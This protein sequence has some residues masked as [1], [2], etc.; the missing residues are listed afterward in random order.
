VPFEPNSMAASSGDGRNSRSSKRLSMNLSSPRRSSVAYDQYGYQ[1]QAEALE[2]FHIHCQNEAENDMHRM[3]RY[4]ACLFDTKG[5]FKDRDYCN[6]V[7]TGIPRTRRRC[8][9]LDC[10]NVIFRIEQNPGH[11]DRLSRAARNDAER[12][13][14]INAKT[15]DDIEKDLY[16]I[17]ENCMRDRDDLAVMSRSVLLAYCIDCKDD[18]YQQGMNFIVYGMLLLR[19]SEEETFWM[20]KFVCQDLFP[21]SFTPAIIGVHADCELLKYYMRYKCKDF[22]R[23]LNHYQI[24]AEIYLHKLVASLGFAV[25]PQESVYKI[26]DRMI[27]GGAVEFFKCLIKLFNAIATKLINRYRDSLWTQ[28]PDSLLQIIDAEL[29][30]MVDITQALIIRIPGAQIEPSA[31]NKRRSK[32]RRLHSARSKKLAYSGRR[33]STNCIKE[34]RDKAMAK[35]KQTGGTVRRMQDMVLD[36]SSSYDSS[37]LI[38]ARVSAEPQ[39]PK[40]SKC[41]FSTSSSEDE[42]PPTRPPPTKPHPSPS[43]SPTLSLA[44]RKNGSSSPPTM[45]SHSSNGTRADVSTVTRSS[46][47][48]TAMFI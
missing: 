9:W 3:V 12:C 41:L 19:F 38:D 43:R 4:E 1:V 22:M 35:P 6:M 44:L 42:A 7:R 40:L 21:I 34:L 11:Y 20:L 13:E 23:I 45:F 27:T 17:G 10:S 24:P 32:E 29:Q 14:L 5:G 25:L 48:E 26:W 8:E 33:D 39:K 36:D 37:T 15:R 47:G 18:G 46:D 30:G 2:A 31:F 16:R 28:R